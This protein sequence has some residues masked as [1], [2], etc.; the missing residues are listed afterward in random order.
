[1]EVRLSRHIQKFG[2]LLERA[3]NR[4]LRVYLDPELPVAARLAIKQAEAASFS[5]HPICRAH[6]QSPRNRVCLDLLAAEITLQR[7]FTGGL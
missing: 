4:H 5:P 7:N 6:R 1:M 3:I 2:L